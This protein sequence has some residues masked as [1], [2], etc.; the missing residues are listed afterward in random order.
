MVTESVEDT[1]LANV[2]RMI[3]TER[4]GTA[5]YSAYNYGRLQV[6]ERI[7]AW[8]TVDTKGS[9]EITIIVSADTSSR[10]LVPLPSV[11]SNMTLEEHLWSAYLYVLE[12]GR[13]AALAEFSR[14]D[15]QFTTQE[16]YVSAWDWNGTMLAHPYRPDLINQDR[17]AYEDVNG[18]HTFSTFEARASHGGGYVLL[19]YPNYLKD[20]ENEVRLVYVQP[21]DETWYIASGMF[22]PEMPKNLDKVER[23]A[24]V[25][26]LR[27]IVQYAHE[28]GKEAAIAALDDPLGPYYNEGRKIVAMDYNGSVLSWP[29]DSTSTGK[30]LLGATDVYGGSFVR[31]LIRT[32]KGGGGFE[33]IYLP[34]QPEGISKLQ[35]QYTLPVDDEWFVSAG[36]PLY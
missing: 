34:I 31:D 3:V 13:D 15:G 2:F 11:S 32:A 5:T 24:M 8:N 6:V 12:N 22:V 25:R 33:Y 7:T 9:G 29:Y 35:L 36:V 1:E 28:Y 27:S 16:F 20:M 23:D 30:N 10:K 26:D 4:K 21:I 19:L 14:P 17:S 18:V